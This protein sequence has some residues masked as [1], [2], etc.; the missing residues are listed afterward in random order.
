MNRYIKNAIIWTGIGLSCFYMGRC[1][2]EKQYEPQIKQEKPDLR[3]YFR[4]QDY[5]VEYSNKR[6]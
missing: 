3:E 6:I 1:S 5:R 2:M 4:Q